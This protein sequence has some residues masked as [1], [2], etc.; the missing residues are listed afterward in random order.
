MS[1]TRRLVVI[2]GLGPIQESVEDVLDDLRPSGW[3]LLRRPRIGAARF[4][5]VV[6]G[7]GGVF[8][9]VVRDGGASLRPEWAD[10]ARA[11]ATMVARLT[12]HAVTPAGRAPARGRL[13]RGAPLPRRRRGAGQRPA[14]LPRGRRRR[15]SGAPR[16]RR[17]A[18]R[19]GSR[20]RP[21]RLSA[22]RSR[23]GPAARRPR[24]RRDRR[25]PPRA[26]LGE[27]E[28]DLDVVG[29]ALEPRLDAAVVVVAHPAGDARAARAPARGLAEEH[30][31]H[32]AVDDDAPGD[33]HVSSPTSS[34]ARTRAAISS[35]WP[36]TRSLM[37]PTISDAR[38]I[39]VLAP[40]S[41]WRMRRTSSSAPSA[42]STESATATPSTPSAP[43]RAMSTR[44]RASA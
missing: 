33:G 26:R 30:A 8:L 18:R 44:A 16:S 42:R 9:V 15:R 21:E 7:P 22:R 2:T 3:H 10:E 31:L 19:C 34:A 40:V 5:H 35:R 25:R 6:V 36:L 38:S 32:A 41:C 1:V 20:S 29:V 13:E 14:A 27:V 12:R 39:C 24:R 37:A 28:H 4:D 11:L 23:A 43:P 17:C